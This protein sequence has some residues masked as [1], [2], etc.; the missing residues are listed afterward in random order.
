MHEGLSELFD[1]I[2]IEDTKH[3][4]SR[5]NAWVREWLELVKNE[6]SVI[7]TSKITS[8]NMDTIKEHLAHG[9]VDELMEMCIKYEISKKITSSEVIAFRRKRRF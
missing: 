2:D 1:I 7:D 4:Q 9:L 8:E 6:Q 5:F 3:R